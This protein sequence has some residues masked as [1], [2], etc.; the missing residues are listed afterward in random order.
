MKKPRRY[1]V[2]LDLTVAMESPHPLAYLHS[3]LDRKLAPGEEIT[4]YTLVDVRNLEKET[5]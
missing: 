4:A 3:L 1:R 2:T 5:L